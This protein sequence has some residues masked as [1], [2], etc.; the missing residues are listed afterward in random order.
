MRREASGTAADLSYALRSYRPGLPLL[1]DPSK[2]QVS[3][4]AVCPDLSTTLNRLPSCRAGAAHAAGRRL[5]RRGSAVPAG[6]GLKLYRPVMRSAL[7]V[8]S[9]R[10]K[11]RRSILITSTP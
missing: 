1:F 8:S 7:Q 5:Q 6:R 9:K 11:M 10:N 2:N 4:E 3:T